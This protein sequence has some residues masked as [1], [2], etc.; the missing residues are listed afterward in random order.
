M[1]YFF[2][3]IRFLC[4]IYTCRSWRLYQDKLRFR[5]QF[6][7]SNCLSDIFSSLFPKRLA[8]STCDSNRYSALYHFDNCSLFIYL[9]KIKKTEG[10]EKATNYSKKIFL[11]YHQRLLSRSFNILCRDV[12]T[13]VYTISPHESSKETSTGARYSTIQIIVGCQ[14]VFWELE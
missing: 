11:S 13:H 9:P 6:L 14:S 8:T 1:Y 7:Q 4:F 5:W 10:L 3:F 2:S 12:S